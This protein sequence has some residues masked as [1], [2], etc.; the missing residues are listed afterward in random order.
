M[1]GMIKLHCLACQT[2]AGTKAVP[3]GV[4]LENDSWIADHCLGAFGMGAIVLKTKA[5]RE[6]LWELT[7]EESS[8]L[9][10]ALKTLSGAMVEAL[11]AERVYVS[12]WVDQPPY[13]VHFVLQPRY[14]GNSEAWGLKGWKLQLVRLFRGKPDSTKAAEASKK[15]RDYL[16][17][18]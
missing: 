14:P 11:G 12:L 8:S 4:I 7:P 17:L 6:N 5:H 13:H 9:G 2:I 18:A 15:I 16:S 1:T 3:G 10:F